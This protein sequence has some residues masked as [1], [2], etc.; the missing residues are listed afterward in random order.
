MARPN[1]LWICTDQQRW[2]TLSCLGF[3]GALTP[4]IDRLAS[5]GVIFKNAYCQS[6]ICTPSRA[7]FLT[8]MYPIANQVHRNGNVGFP[9]H[10]ELV[11]KILKKSGYYNGLIGKLHLS[12]TQGMSEVR[13]D[14]GYDE[15]YPK[16]PVGG[17]G[18]DYCAWLE[19]KSFDINKLSEPREGICDP[20]VE[21]EYSQTV[22]SGERAL[23][24]IERNV[25]KP[26][27]LSVNV[28][29]PHPPFDP[30]SEY[31]AKF[32]PE[33]MPDA[34]F[35]QSD[36]EHQKRFAGVDQQA[37]QA[38][39]PEDFHGLDN[40]PP[41]DTQN[42]MFMGT[43]DTPPSRYNAREIR[44]AYQAMIL[45]IDDMVGSLVVKL[46]ETGQLEKTI[47]VFTSDHGEMLGDHGLLYKGCRFYEGLVHVPLIIVIP[48][49]MLC[50]VESEALV[51]LVDI[52]PTLL[53]LADIDVPIT[54]QGKSL[55]PMLKGEDALDF[56]KP[57]VLSEYF[58]CLRFPGSVGSRGS[59]YFDGRFKLNIYHDIGEGELFDL[60][61]DPDEFEDRWHDP[62]YSDIKSGLISK[63]FNAMMKVS[64]AGPE[65]TH[66][67]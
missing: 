34:K 46:K 12:R 60:K 33:N 5:R 39:I 27:L 53:D 1:I 13:P 44:A 37:K 58:D 41:A 54:M 21:T 2:D 38:V 29:D 31:M 47:I 56:H 4:H 24:F 17:S 11:P 16:G 51:E 59:M 26:W 42:E 8:G 36:I 28:F 35:R 3:K 63:H 30:P 7:S 19:E 65:R 32:N 9:E 61:S 48:E 55:A 67:F 50:G 45:L 15:F 57:Y 64:G 6:P 18:S 66:D 22:W 10:L 20:S 25:D 40:V 62:Q 49:S 14:D 52:A 23:N 43:H